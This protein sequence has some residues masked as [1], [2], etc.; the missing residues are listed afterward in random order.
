MRVPFA[1]PTSLTTCSGMPTSKAKAIPLSSGP[2]I[3]TGGLGSSIEWM[4]RR[5]SAAS[6]KRRSSRARPSST[7]WRG[8]SST[9]GVQT[10][11]KSSSTKRDAYGLAGSKRE[12]ASML[13]KARVKVPRT[14]RTP[15]LRSWST[16]MAPQISLPCVSALTSTCGPGLPLSKV[17]TKSVPVADLRWGWMSGAW[18]STATGGMGSVTGAMVVMVMVVV[19]VVVIVAARVRAP[20]RVCGEPRDEALEVRAQ[21]IE[22]RG[23]LARA[24]VHV[25][26]AVHLELQAV[27]PGRGIGERAH[28][29]HAFVRIVEAHV[30]AHVAEP[31]G[32][33]RGEFRRAGRA[34][35]V[36]DD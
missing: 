15:R 21:P 23:F 26:P 12:N 5:K 30:V 31:L 9:S 24:L 34:V 32:D 35:A 10:R 33:E 28:E 6:T 19:I 8:P 7:L 1:W 16:T 27:A 22:S 17:W 25:E 18:S 20:G 11:L 2:Q 3:I 29:L 14:G 4:S 36:A 13:A